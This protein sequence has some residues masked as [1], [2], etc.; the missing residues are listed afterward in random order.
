L[1][2]NATRSSSQPTTATDI[3]DVIPSVDQRRLIR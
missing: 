1:N 2:G 3:A